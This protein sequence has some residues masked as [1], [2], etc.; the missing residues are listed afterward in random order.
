[1]IRT[2]SPAS[3]AT[4]SRSRSEADTFPAADNAHVILDLAHG[5][6]N[7]AVDTSLTV[8]SDT[9]ISGSRV[10]EGWGG[11]R[12]VY[13][14]MQFSKPFTSVALE[15]DGQRL[16]AD[17]RAGRGQ[18]M[19]ASFNYA[20]AANETILV[21]IGLSGT[22]IE[23]AR[24]NLAAEI[25]GW[26]FDGARA[27][28]VAQWKKVFAGVEVESFDPHIRATFYANLYLSCLAPVLF[29]DVDGNYRGMDHKNHSGEGFQNYTTFSL[30]DTYRA[31]HPAYTLFES[32]RVPDFANSLIR[33]AVESPMTTFVTGSLFLVG[34]ARAILVPN[35]G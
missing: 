25:P 33:M 35:G 30:W 34:E 32:G 26:D 5:V 31:A 21:K 8:E 7:K 18:S 10:S 9:T 20:P 17:A 19:K 23:G 3:S 16:A 22:G 14:V 13:F 4:C 2:T 12:A 6:G 1:M 11:R 28:A 29:N 15:R 27:G 24:K